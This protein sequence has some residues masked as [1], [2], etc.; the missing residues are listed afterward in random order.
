MVIFTFPL[1]TQPD[2]LKMACSRVD[3]AQI[4]TAIRFRLSAAQ[5]SVIWPG[6]DMLTKSYLSRGRKGVT[7]YEY[8][9]RVYPPRGGFDRGEFDQDMMDEVLAVGERLRPKAKLGGR[10]QMDA[11]ELRAAIFAIRSNLDYVRKGRHDR[12]LWSQETKAKFLLDDKSYNQ[13][14]IKSPRVILSLER[15]T[16]RA[17]RVLVK[18]VTKAG[19]T[20]L[21]Q[22]WK[23]HLRW[24]HL[25]IAYF[26]RLP[27]V[28][29]GRRIEHQKTLDSLMEMAENGIR[30]EGFE[31]PDG[32][33]LRRVM[34]L[35]VRSA[36]R[37]RESI[38]TIPYLLR[39]YGY[40]H[41]NR[42][43]ARFV[44]TRLTLKELP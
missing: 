37:G 16:K 41:L 30:D 28:I 32:K 27:P 5:M 7:R 6:L 11:I 12:R 29:P 24:M 25:H 19:Y 4:T 10:I 35:Y 23:A 21:M 3:V 31:A 1:S 2:N 34:R 26:K 36:R 33:E 22:V 8:P 17:N 39:H 13:L 15:H 38:Y 43:L 40:S 9:F 14:K 42:Y 44:I 18:A 20:A